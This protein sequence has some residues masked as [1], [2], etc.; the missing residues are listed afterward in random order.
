MP[1]IKTFDAGDVQIRPS[2]AGSAAYRE[3]GSVA[4]RAARTIGEE[5]R[6]EGRAIGS[7]IAAFGAGFD[8]MRDEAQAHTDAMAEIDFQHQLTQAEIAAQG[9]VNV[10]G[11]PTTSDGT[12]INDHPGRGV[13][14]SLPPDANVPSPNQFSVA[15]SDTIDNHQSFLGGLIDRITGQGVSQKAV[16]RMNVQAARSR[17]RIALHANAVAGEVAFTHATHTTE[18][19]INGTLAAVRRGD[20]SID[21]G[22]AHIDGAL[23]AFKGSLSGDFSAKGAPFIENTR[24]KARQQAIVASIEGDLA[25][26]RADNALRTLND[27]K[28]D[29]DIGAVRGK[30][31]SEVSSFQNAQ[32]RAQETE[33]KLK[34]DQEKDAAFARTDQYIQDAA[35]P[36]PQFKLQDIWT[37][38]VYANRPDLRKEAVGVFETMK[39]FQTGDLNVSPEL[40]HTTTLDLMTRLTAPE[41]DPNRI[42]DRRPID[43]ALIDQK[44]NRQDYN[45]L[46]GRLKAVDAPFDKMRTHLETAVHAQYKA[47]IDTDSL[48]GG[49]SADMKFYRWQH[50]LDDRIKEYRAQGKDPTSLLTP[51]N[52]DY[53]G[54]PQT[55]DSFKSS[56]QQNLRQP[57]QPNTFTDP[58]IER[59]AR[60]ISPIES[61]S[62]Q[63][64]YTLVSKASPS[65]DRAYG[66]YQ[67]MGANVGPWTEKWYG[68]RLTPQDF[69]QNKAAQDAV[70]AG[71]FGEYMKKYGP[72]GA[73]R[74]WYAG[75]GGMKNSGA[76]DVYGRL[77]VGDYG[78]QFM[79][80]FQPQQ[81]GA[82]RISTAADYAKLAPGTQYIDPNGVTRIKGGR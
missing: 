20:M 66:R 77:T 8:K 16:E 23:G 53:F 79:K 64:N 22:M 47:A 15:A 50:A 10:A 7:G 29:A 36:N 31:Q 72:E 4:S 49:E 54:S 6:Q 2:E 13:D 59:A 35:S 38:P 27:P 5:V 14:K 39:K 52:S 43:Q 3:L 68:K 28:W 25:A 71:Q 58:N 57:Q 65:G 81:T 19:T 82:V 46:M 18:Q 48:L 26:G 21:D 51:G 12:P 11:T 17:D 75:E 40:S 62:P 61:G 60:A 1:N 45:F 37:D 32:V 73:A 67:V 76:T 56:M 44:V 30:I 78:Q 42:T 33:R 24:Q 74:A 70:F 55:I 41:G 69:L 9:G 63:G 80:N 34:L